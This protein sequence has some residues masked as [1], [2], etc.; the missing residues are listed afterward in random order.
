MNKN[1]TF[2]NNDLSLSNK[3]GNVI[4]Y[5]IFSFIAVILF[6]LLG[7]IIPDVYGDLRT[8]KTHDASDSFIATVTTNETLSPIKEGIKTTVVTRRNHTWLDF[9]GANDYLYIPQYDYVSVSFWVKNSNSSWIHIV[10]SSDLIYENNVT[11][12]DLTLNAF[13][14]NATGWYFGVNESH[15][16]NGSIDTI[17]FYNDTMNESQVSELFEAGR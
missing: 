16:F 1:E 12:G 9:D 6:A 3:K 7:A 17:K 2:C 10:N 14:S 8:E 13:T 15:F 11:V 5:V 4:I